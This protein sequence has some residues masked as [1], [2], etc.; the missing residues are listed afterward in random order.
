V[1]SLDR[2]RLPPI[3]RPMNARSI[4]VVLAATLTLSGAWQCGDLAPYSVSIPS[5]LADVI[6]FRVCD[7]FGPPDDNPPLCPI[8]P[9]A[10]LCVDVV[11]WHSQASVSEAL[12]AG[13]TMSVECATKIGDMSM[14]SIYPKTGTWLSCEEDCQY[15]FGDQPEGA[16]CEAVGHRMS[17]CEEG[18][19]CAPDRRCHQ[20]CDYSFIAPLGGWCGPARGMWFVTCDAGLRCGPEGTCQPA[21]AIGESCVDN[22]GCAIGGWCD[23]ETNLCTS[24]GADGTPCVTD[25]QCESMVCVEGRCLEEE[26]FVCQRYGW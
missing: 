13:Y 18:L 3:S 11:S 19:I 25:D 22:F 24:V 16:A 23:T 20:P 10:Q 12:A 5:V 26:P 14:A 8:F 15:F 7:H 1:E 17:D 21:A 4:S 2:P 9:Y 6:T